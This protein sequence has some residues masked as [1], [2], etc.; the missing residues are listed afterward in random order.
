MYRDLASASGQDAAQMKIQP[1]NV[2]KHCYVTPIGQYM[3]TFEHFWT[4]CPVSDLSI[5]TFVKIF[6]KEHD[7]NYGFTHFN[8]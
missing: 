8:N 1:N 3:T 6:H 2:S 4:A 5:I 7:D